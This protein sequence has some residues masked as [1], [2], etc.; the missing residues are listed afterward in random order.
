MIEDILEYNETIDITNCNTSQ[1]KKT[2]PTTLK[3][4]QKQMKGFDE[5]LVM[6]VYHHLNGREEEAKSYL[7]EWN[8][9]QEEIANSLKKQNELKYAT[10]NQITE[11]GENDEN[12]IISS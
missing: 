4:V 7:E 11:L 6:Y 1:Q 9:E 8:E 10:E 3:Q 12:K 5:S 2:I